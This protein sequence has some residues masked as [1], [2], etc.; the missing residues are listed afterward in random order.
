[1]P[2]NDQAALDDAIRSYYDDDQEDQR[3]FS[4][5][6][7]LELAR[8]QEIVA[9]Y[10]SPVELAILDVGGGTGV[11][12]AWLAGLGHIV[13]LIDPVPLHVERALAR[14]ATNPEYTFTAE[15]GDARSLSADD[16]SFDAV[17]LFGPL[18][19]LTER[20]DRLRALAEARRVLQ[21]G[22][23]LFAVGVS[24]FA[25]LLDGLRE[26]WLDDPAFRQIVERDLVEGQHRNPT[27][28]QGW[29]TT[30]YMHHPDELRDEVVESGFTLDALFGVEGPGWPLKAD[31]DDPS[32]R[33]QMLYAARAV[34]REPTLLGMSPHLLVVART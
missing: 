31:W 3:L 25:P 7:R 30:A 16:A 8:T 23:R 1:M 33:A 34:E 13:H 2:G 17:L 5:L 11:Y 32:M 29:F 26:G 27:E 9:R 22:G 19:H 24:R 10:L 18:Y 15:I 14:A 4:R 20:A 12:A 28:R 6:G 21:P